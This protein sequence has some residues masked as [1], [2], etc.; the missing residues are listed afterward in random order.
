MNTNGLNINTLI[1]SW[2]SAL[3][4]AVCVSDKAALA[5]AGGIHSGAAA[6]RFSEEGVNGAA[7]GE[8]DVEVGVNGDAPGENDGVNGGAGGENDGVKEGALER[9]RN[10]EEDLRGDEGGVCLG[11]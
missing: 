10:G 6:E 1:S 9:R 2:V 3:I 11:S 7:V 5:F 4:P 8:D